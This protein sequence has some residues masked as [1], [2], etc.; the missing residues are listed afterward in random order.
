MGIVVTFPELGNALNSYLTPIIFDDTQNLGSPLI[1]SF[2]LCLVGFACSLIAFFLDRRADK[3]LLLGCR[4]M[5][6]ITW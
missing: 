3:V 1:F 5:R 4:L 6:G 2:G